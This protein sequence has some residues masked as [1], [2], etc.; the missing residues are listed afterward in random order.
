MLRRAL[1][2]SCLA[3]VLGSCFAL[4]LAGCG[5]GEEHET[6]SPAAPRA[7][8]FLAIDP[9]IGTAGLGFGVGSAYPGPAVPFAMIHPSPDTRTQAGWSSFYH[10]S[11]CYAS[12]PLLRAFSLVHFEGTGVPDYGAIGLLPTLAMTDAKRTE[13]GRMVALDKASEE[14]RPG[15]YAVTLADGIRVEITASRRAAT[16]RF[17]FP[18]SATPALL[19][20]LDHALEGTITQ[21]DYS[22]AGPDLNLHVH[23]DGGMSGGSGGYDLFARGVVDVAPKSVGGYDAT[24]LTP[25]QASASASPLG[26]WL[27][28]PA[29]TRT[30]N[31][32]LGVS[33]VDAKGAQANLAAEAPSFDFE[34]MRAAAETEWKKETDRVEVYGA[35][36]YDTTIMGTAIYHAHLMPTLM[37][38]VDGRYVN[39]QGKIA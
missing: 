35:G 3:L 34:G 25:G 13:E 15:Y 22:F 26:A 20:A 27:E 16:F 33:F 21:K 30:V 32:R 23:H 1:L 8:L 39:V 10:C 9:R 14:M 18:E 31:L 37:S 7:D 12:D 19:F 11:G 2:G 4:V 17:G 5:D 28:F 36:E 38:D 29:G 24:E 6:K